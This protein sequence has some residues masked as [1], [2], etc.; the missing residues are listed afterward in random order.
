MVGEG[1]LKSMAMVWEAELKSIGSSFSRM[2]VQ[3]EGPVLDRQRAGAVKRK[4]RA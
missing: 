2:T 4:A 3:P 1:V